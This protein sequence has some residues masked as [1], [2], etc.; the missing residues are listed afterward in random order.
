M[1][2]KVIIHNS[3]SLDGSLTNFEPNMELHYQIAGRYKPN[4]HLVGSNTV[5]VGIE[6]YG[7]G[8]PPEEE[9]DYE[10]PERP[11][12]LPYWVIPDTKGML[13]GLL[14][15]CRR[16]ELCRDVI[17]LISE[18]TPEEYVAHLK[19]RNYDYH[20]VGKEHAD[21]KKAL[22]LVSS[23][24]KVKKVLTDTG[25]ILG[26][27]LLE[28]GLVSELSLLVHPVIVG[29]KSY[30]MFGNISKSINLRLYKK[31]IFSKGYTWLVYKVRNDSS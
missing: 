28:Q 29:E 17:V 11:R 30:N 16:S 2:P 20:V 10:K 4:V 3:I 27:L 19:E 5:K 22:E 18:S 7:N 31:E 8:I 26:N 15:T 9:T 12:N 23:E 25:R 21:L 14:H 1:L 6:L 13:K 24:Y